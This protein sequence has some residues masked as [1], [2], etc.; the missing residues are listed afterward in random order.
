MELHLFPTF[1]PI[2]LDQIQRSDILHW[3]AAVGARIQNDDYSPTTANGWLRILRTILNAGAF[4]FDWSKNPIDRI[5]PFDT[6]MHHTYTEEEPNALTASE[7]HEFLRVMEQRFP[8][9]HAM[10]ALGFYTGLRPSSLRPLRRQGR[11]ADVLW[12]TGEIL[13]RRSHSARRDQILERTKTGKRQRIPLPEPI[14]ETLR[15]HVAAL[16]EGPMRESELLFP[17]WDGGVRS[18][19]VLVKPFAMVEKAIGLKK[20]VTP[21]AMRRTL[22]DLCRETQVPDVVTRAIS[23]HATEAMHITTHRFAETRSESASATLSLS[24]VH[25]AKAR[26]R[27]VVCM[28]V[29]TVHKCRKPARG[30]VP[31]RPRLLRFF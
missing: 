17:A 16:A 12:D 6:S 26:P 15:K 29:C 9:H 13:I 8:Q 2:F 4:E 31:N 7:L 3:K 30:E 11:N 20:H 28:V 25:R 24:S 27:L 19:G 18:R 14:M 22:Q 5:K 10:V 23:G 1:G 21:R